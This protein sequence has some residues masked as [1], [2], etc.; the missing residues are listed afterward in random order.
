MLC[1]C[2]QS[3]QESP[4]VPWPAFFATIAPIQEVVSE[5]DRVEPHVLRS[6]RHGQVLGPGHVPLDLGELHADAEAS[7]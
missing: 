1:A 3:G 5:P 6:T 2:R 7:C 4:G